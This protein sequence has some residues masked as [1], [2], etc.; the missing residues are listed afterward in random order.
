[1]IVSPFRSSRSQRSLRIQRPAGRRGV[2]YHEH[3]FSLRRQVQRSL[4]HTDMRLDPGQHDLIASKRGQTLREIQVQE[5][6]KNPSFP[7]AAY[8]RQSLPDFLDRSAQAFGILLGQQNGH[9][10][11]FG[12]VQEKVYPRKHA[13]MLMHMRKQT[14]LKIDEHE[15][16]ARP[17][18]QFRF[19]NRIPPKKT[20]KHKEPCRLQKD[21]RRK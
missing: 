15:R 5:R 11:Q 16:A 4:C 12:G 21:F 7:E 14:L 2:R 17:V 20:L 13:L 3:I 19:H 1:M 8:L 6:R 10:H 9:L 18:Q